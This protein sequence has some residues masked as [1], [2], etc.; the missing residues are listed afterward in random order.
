VG[1]RPLFLSK[2]SFGVR[3]NEVGDLV[4][5]VVE[6]V[7]LELWEVSFGR[8]DGR[9]ILRVTVDRAGGGEKEGGVDLDTIA[10]TSQRL[11]R[12]LDLEGFE[13]DRP[14]E[15][16]VSSPGLERALREPRHF[17]RSVGQ[18]VR[19]KTV[20]PVSDRRVHE[21]A[22][23]S[24]DAEAIVIAS[25]GGELRVPYDGIA[26]ARTVFEWKKAGSKT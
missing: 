4:R 15:L 25:E 17:E 11:S 18:Q 5:P 10:A 9:R 8:E 13:Q 12:R 22:L 3:E 14:Y 21:G 26:S 24:A 20:E 1:S 19:V 16:Q 6:A 7:G 23:V 2:G